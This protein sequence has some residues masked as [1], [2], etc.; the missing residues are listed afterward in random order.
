MTTSA[1]DVRSPH[2]LRRIAPALGTALAVGLAAGYVWAV[3][4]NA[5]VGYP[6]CPTQ[7]FL[8]IDCPACGGLRGSH[9]L[10]RGDFAGAADNNVALFVLLPAL[11]IVWFRWLASSW[12]GLPAA[13]VSAG[14]SSR[15]LIAV[16]IAVGIFGVV[17]NFVP[18]LGS[19]IG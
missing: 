9:S 11:A 10:M 1:A 18:Y 7:A 4:P 14:P 19:G 2:R 5:G 17:R 15:L 3:D 8:G 13:S 6:T 16:L 12:K